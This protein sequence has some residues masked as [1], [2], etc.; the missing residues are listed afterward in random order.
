M[1][2]RGNMD[3]SFSAPPASD[4]PG[5]HPRAGFLV[6]RMTAFVNIT[7]CSF[8]SYFIQVG[9]ECYTD[10]VQRSKSTTTAD[11]QTAAAA[12]MKRKASAESC[13]CAAVQQ[14]ETV[15]VSDEPP[16]K[17][18]RRTSIDHS[19]CSSSNSASE[20]SDRRSVANRSVGC[21]TSPTK[22]RLR[23]II[24]RQR[25][26]ICRLA[27]ESCKDYELVGVENIIRANRKSKQLHQLQQIWP[28]S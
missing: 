24:R 19:Y 11:D 27:Q 8:L 23:A 22:Q 9:R 14:A 20:Q 18:S 3:P 7:A 5:S 25:V 6:M 10:A 28:H 15:T 21:P 16:S 2:W 26:Q 1:D 17:V 13:A 4:W 12:A